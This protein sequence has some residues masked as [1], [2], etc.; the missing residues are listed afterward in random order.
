MSIKYDKPFLTF[1]EQIELMRKRGIVVQNNDYTL[2]KLSSISYYSLINGYKNTLLQDNKK[3]V[4]VKGTTFD[5]IYRLYL[6]DSSLSNT[7]LKYILYVER[8]LKTKLSYRIA[9]MY[10]VHQ[11]DYLDSLNYFTR[12]NNLVSKVLNHL[13]TK[14]SSP[15]R[16]TTSYYYANN[17]NHLPPWILVNDISFNITI[18]W[19]KILKGVD[20]SFIVENMI[21]HNDGSI[22]V[23]D[24][25]ELLNKSLQ[26]LLDYRNSLAHGNKVFSPH[27]KTKLPK[28]PLLK[29]INN[30]LILDNMEYNRGLGQKDLF[31]IASS[32]LLLI[33]NPDILASCVK[34]ISL[35]FSEFK[36][37][38]YIGK[39]A[40]ELLEIPKNFHERLS[41]LLTE[42][43]QHSNIG[44]FYDSKSPN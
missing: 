23:V 31:A 39:Y 22:S 33:N 8:A 10:G 2:E 41:V 34:D 16:N 36:D 4:F 40:F 18:E 11:N 30:P 37:Q 14:C 1:D 25:K 12:N 13:K 38:Q 21:I 28:K 26:L 6:F 9:Q 20:K 44:G 43:L 29:I 27:I 15:M 19:Y 5:M 7:L 3:D 24:K 35:I 17:K 42:R 32:L